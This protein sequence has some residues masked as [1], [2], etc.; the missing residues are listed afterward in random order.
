MSSHPFSALEP[1]Y[2]QLLGAMVIT[3]AQEVDQTA[4]R[5]LQRIPV[6][7]AQA[8]REEQV[9]ALWL[10]AVG[11]REFGDHFDRYFGNGDPLARKTVDV[12]RDRG[13][14]TGPNA[15]QDGLR[16]AIT[17]DHIAAT[18]PPW[19]WAG[20]CYKGEAWNGFGPRAHGKHTGY[21]WAGTNIYTGGKYVRDNV[22]DPNAQ[23]EQLGIIPVM[24]RMAHIAPSFAFDATSPVRAALAVPAPQP[25]PTGVHDAETLQEALNALG[26]NPALVTDGSYG[27]QTAAAVRAFQQRSSLPV[28]GIAGT[29]TWTAITKA[30]T[31]HKDAHPN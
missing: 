4:A 27:R 1:E 30:L 18:P 21:L 29:A 17:Y 14:F 2:S 28:D 3:R 9:P 26:T 24:W 6:F 12:P 25:P 20:A 15:F 13:P 23:D 10:A 31:D 16:D 11:E 5:L 22:W 7:Y 8:A 19:S